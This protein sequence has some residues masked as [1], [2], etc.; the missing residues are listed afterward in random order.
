M[1]T[2]TVK[3]VL[4]EKYIESNKSVP[5]TGGTHAFW[6]KSD[7]TERKP[8]TEIVAIYWISINSD[9]P[10]CRNFQ[11]QNWDTNC[12]ETGRI[13]FGLFRRFSFRY[14]SNNIQNIN[15]QKNRLC[16][17]I[18]TEQLTWQKLRWWDRG[19]LDTHFSHQKI[20]E[21]WRENTT[22]RYSVNSD[23]RIGPKRTQLPPIPCILI[24]GIVPRE[25]THSNYISNKSC[26]FRNLKFLQFLDGK[27]EENTRT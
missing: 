7:F 1:R 2:P 10:F 16:A 20:G 6:R 4:P 26:S 13:L 8:V 5:H 9:A 27:K 19:S 3:L 25:H 24:P 15:S 21:N 14:K 11:Q 18:K 23:I 22:N 17:I 12:P